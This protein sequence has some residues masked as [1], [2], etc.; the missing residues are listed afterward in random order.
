MSRIFVGATFTVALGMVVVALLEVVRNILLAHRILNHR[1]FR[2]FVGYATSS[3][4]AI[5]YSNLSVQDRSA[6]VIS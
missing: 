3:N 1:H 2:V 4:Y 5:L 6:I